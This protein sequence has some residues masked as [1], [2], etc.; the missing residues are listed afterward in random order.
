MAAVIPTETTIYIAPVDTAVASAAVDTYKIAG[1]ITNWKVSGG[2][3]DV[4]L[5]Q[6]FGGQVDKVKPREQIEVSFDIITS[7]INTSA[8]DRYNV[9]TMGTG[10]TSAGTALSKTIVFKFV[11]NSLT[12]T[13]AMNNCKAITWDP[14]MAADDM[15]KGTMTFKLSPTTPLGLA[16]LKASTGAAVTAFVWTV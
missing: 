11:T 9:Y 15:L 7:N 13:L 10:M 6:T 5:V 4:E 16:N 14:E 12:Q 1:E 8:L 3:S 2:Q